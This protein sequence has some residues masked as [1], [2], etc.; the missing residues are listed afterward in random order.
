MVTPDLALSPLGITWPDAGP[1]SLMQRY[2]ALAS[3]GYAVVE[4]GPGAW[5]WTERLGEHGRPLLVG[6]TAVRPLRADELPPL[7]PQ[8]ATS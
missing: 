3:L 6:L 4:G 8:A 7:G 1:P 2:D 5:E